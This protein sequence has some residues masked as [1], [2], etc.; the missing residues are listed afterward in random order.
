MK[1]YCQSCGTSIAYSHADKPSFC[2]SC[3]QP[4]GKKKLAQTSEAKI[5]PGADSEVEDDF[6]DDSH[7]YVPDNIYKLEFEMEGSWKQQGVRI[8]D[9]IPKPDDPEDA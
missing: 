2:S 8:R 1:I 7:L 4:L 3:G 5:K 6:E 9:M